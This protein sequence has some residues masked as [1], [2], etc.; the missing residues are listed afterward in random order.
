MEAWERKPMT[1]FEFWAIVIGLLGI[2]V[3]IGTGVAIYCQAM[4]A[5]EAN[6]ISRETLED[7]TRPWVGI[8]GEYYVPYSLSTFNLVITNYGNSPALL[9][10]D[11]LGNP[12]SKLRRPDKDEIR[13]WRLK[14]K[15][16]ICKQYLTYPGPVTD[17]PQFPV[18]VFQQKS[19]SR[20]VSKMIRPEEITNPNSMDLW[21]CVPYGGPDGHPKYQTNVL[22]HVDFKSN[23]VTLM[24]S[25]F[26]SPE[27]QKDNEIHLWRLLLF[28]T[29]F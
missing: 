6:R 3:A 17:R 13:F 21:V 2:L 28:T 7:Q 1:R 16:D 4:T 24:D 8:D 23:T 27:T 20:P 25:D 18:P 9:A 10:G 12:P 11:A 22:Y 5:A 14:F 15:E 19:I 29:G 26:E